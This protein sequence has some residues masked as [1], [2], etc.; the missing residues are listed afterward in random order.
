LGDA[1]FAGEEILGEFEIRDD[2]VPWKA[3]ATQPIF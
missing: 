3:V 1:K 2:K